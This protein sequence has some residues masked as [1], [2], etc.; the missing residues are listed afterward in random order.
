MTDV[1]R[2]AFLA[3]LLGLAAPLQLPGLDAQTAQP[4]AFDRSA[5]SPMY[6]QPLDL[7]G[8]TQTFESRF[9]PG[10][11]QP[12]NSR[13]P[14]DWYAGAQGGPYGLAN[15]GYSVRPDV[16]QYVRDRGLVIRANRTPGVR[17]DVVGGWYS[18]HLQTVN[19][20]GQG[21]AQTYGY[22][23]AR[24]KF[25]L[26]YMAWPAFWLK[27]RSKW[28][29]PSAMN[30][31]IDVIE[32]YGVNEPYIHHRTVHLGPG[33]GGV[34]RRRWHSNTQQRTE[35]P[36][37]FQNYGVLLDEDWVTIY[38]NRRA[39]A[40]HPMIEEYRQPL[41][42]QVTLSVNGHAKEVPH[43]AEAHNPMELHVEYVS[44]WAPTP[45]CRLI[46]C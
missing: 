7:T 2:R 27:H 28:T 15:V 25:P 14:A 32:W 17:P 12:G 8:M 3:G 40:R 34:P 29:D 30:I 20:Y 31:E 9:P 23:E 45:P 4:D 38:I 16:Y 26:S 11:I 41:Y 1:R 39:A 22:F 33:P 6:G 46:K 35:D 44:V 13:L 18:G 21:F 5:W 10:S 42:P 37:R 19:I 24:M 43:A 36:T